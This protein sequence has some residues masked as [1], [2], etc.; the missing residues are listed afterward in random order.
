MAA[1]HVLLAEMWR[2][3]S[4]EKPLESAVQ[5]NFLVQQCSQIRKPILRAR[6]SKWGVE[7]SLG[8]EHGSGDRRALPVPLPREPGVGRQANRCSVLTQEGR[9]HATGCLAFCF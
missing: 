8:E 9:R 3:G 1:E 2:K 5:C 6:V 4:W 7:V